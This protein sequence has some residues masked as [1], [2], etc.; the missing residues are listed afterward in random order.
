MP[1]AL[2]SSASVISQDPSLL[3]SVGAGLD[4]AGVGFHPPV[5][6]CHWRVLSKG[7]M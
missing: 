6:G 5:L 4:L 2:A 7:G 1:G 3:G